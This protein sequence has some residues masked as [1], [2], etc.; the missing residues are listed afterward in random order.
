MRL[1]P[2]RDCS[3]VEPTTNKYSSERRCFHRGDRKSNGLTLEMSKSPSSVR[4]NPHINH[5]LCQYETAPEGTA[6]T[7]TASFGSFR[8]GG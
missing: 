7:S 8:R 6:R 1:R 5:R 2:T 4:L 3:Q